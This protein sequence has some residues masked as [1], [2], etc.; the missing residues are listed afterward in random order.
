MG[1]W[2]GPANRRAALVTGGSDSL[3]M[4]HLLHKPMALHFGLGH[5]YG[6]LEWQT[7]ARVQNALHREHGETLTV[8]HASHLDLGAFEQDDGYVPYRNLLLAAAAALHAD[9]LYVGAVRGDSSRDKSARFFRDASRLL[10]YLEDRRVTVAAPLRRLTKTQAVALFLERWPERADLLRVTRSCYTLDA[11]D[12]EVVGCGRC[13]A[14]FGRWVA[15]SNNGL[16][17]RYEYPP[18]SW[19][20][21]AGGHLTRDGWGHSLL[22][23][24]PRELYGVLRANWDT[25][26]ALRRNGRTT[27]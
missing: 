25:Y 22:R 21:V 3:I 26:R 27:R 2:N 7:L 19:D 5:R 17:E 8:H 13:L 15:F 14:C 20:K 24:P 16:F 10:S 6:Q 1:S 4:W 11:Y 18:W 9:T 23:Q 12:E